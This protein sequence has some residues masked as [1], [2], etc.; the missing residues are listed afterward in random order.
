MR[1]TIFDDDGKELAQGYVNDLKLDSRTRR[2]DIGATVMPDWRPI[3]EGGH[4]AKSVMDTLMDHM[5]ASGKAEVSYSRM[6]Q[7]VS[8]VSTGLS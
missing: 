1:I 6:P 2:V 7:V 8:V 3:P 5:V 4:S